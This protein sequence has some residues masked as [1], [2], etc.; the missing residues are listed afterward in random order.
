MPGTMRCR[1]LGICNKL[2]TVSAMTGLQVHRFSQGCLRQMA[3]DSRAG[4]HAA[5]FLPGTP[6]SG[7]NRREADSHT[8]KRF[9]RA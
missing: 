1:G 5:E 4:D 6:R 8:L 3:H 2:S 7:D 9:G